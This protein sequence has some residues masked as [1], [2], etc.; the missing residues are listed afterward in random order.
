VGV[1]E[2]GLDRQGAASRR[3]R[4]DGDCGFYLR[5]FTPEETKIAFARLLSMVAAFAFATTARNKALK[6]FE[7]LEDQREAAQACNA[8]ISPIVTINVTIATNIAAAESDVN[9]ITAHEFLIAA[10]SGPSRFRSRRDS[11]SSSGSRGRPRDAASPR[12]G[13]H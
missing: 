4:I 7:E 13:P 12:P 5:A 1:V 9:H 8:T 2:T 10:P 3:W 11:R 6:S